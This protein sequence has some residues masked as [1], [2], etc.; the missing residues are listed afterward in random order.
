MHTYLKYLNTLMHFKQ[1]YYF[2]MVARFGVGYIKRSQI[3]YQVSE[4][5]L[6]QDKA[7]GCRKKNS[8]QYRI[9]QGEK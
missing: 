6:I 1:C 4:T 3:N 8:C 7:H 2:F 9:L 5:I